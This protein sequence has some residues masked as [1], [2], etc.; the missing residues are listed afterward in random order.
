MSARKD[1]TGMRFGRLLVRAPAES[2]AGAAAWECLCDCGAV[3]VVL[4]SEIRKGHVRSCGC[5]RRDVLSASG[6][7]DGRTGTPEWRVWRDMLR[8]CED[9]GVDAFKHYGARGIAVCE[10]WHEF[11]NFLADMG[12]RPAGMTLERADVDGNY[13]P[14]N[15]SWIPAGEQSR[16]TRRTVRVSLGGEEL[17]LKVACGRL[18]I[19]YQRT[20][21]RMKVL[22][23][24][25]ERAANEPKKVNGTMY[26][27]E[28]AR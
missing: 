23:W 11:E 12:R 4:G 10:R 5:F 17:C 21:D 16:N 13:E 18:G 7:K 22:G 9:S 28:D 8:R 2:K 3:K 20:R 19:S 15:C 27:Q 6:Y 24:T 26:A 25:F 1:M 14:S